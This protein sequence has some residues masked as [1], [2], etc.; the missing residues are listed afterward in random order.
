LIK[1]IRES[2]VMKKRTVG[3]ISL[4]VYSLVIMFSAYFIGI[5]TSDAST[6]ETISTTYKT[7]KEE[8]YYTAKEK[9]GKL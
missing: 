8:E 3:I 2:E 7:A 9:D 4:A 6:K 1:S 5:N